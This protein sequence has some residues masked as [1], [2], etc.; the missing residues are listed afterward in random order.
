MLKPGNQEGW[1]TTPTSVVC[2]FSGF[3]A[4]LPRLIFW[5]WNGTGGV[6]KVLFTVPVVTVWAANSSLRLGARMSRDCSAR[7]RS[8]SSGV[9]QVAPTFQVLAEPEVL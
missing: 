8:P 7:K 9:C 1:D 2:A 6:K 3:S 5:I 4:V